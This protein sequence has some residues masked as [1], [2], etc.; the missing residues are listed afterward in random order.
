MVHLAG[1]CFC[2][3]MVQVRFFARFPVRGGPLSILTE[4]NLMYFIDNQIVVIFI[5]EWILFPFLLLHLLYT[6][7]VASYT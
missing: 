2:I 4:I 7:N 5:C 6:A 3:G 1:N